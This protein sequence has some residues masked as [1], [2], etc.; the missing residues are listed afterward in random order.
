MPHA[1]PAVVQFA[2]LYKCPSPLAGGSCIFG[3]DQQGARHAVSAKPGMPFLDSCTGSFV[4]NCARGSQCDTLRR[5]QN[6]P[7]GGSSMCPPWAPVGPVG[8]DFVLQLRGLTPESTYAVSVYN[9]SFS[10]TRR[11]TTTGAQLARWTVT[12]RR[13]SSVLFWFQRLSS[14]VRAPPKTTN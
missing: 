12:L 7:P 4:P 6:A 13:R 3:L 5:A 11:L 2:K 8:H 9:E 10:E 1:H 14:T